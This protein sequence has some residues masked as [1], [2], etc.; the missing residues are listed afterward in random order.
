MIYRLKVSKTAARQVREAAE[1]WHGHRR[2]AA[3]ALAD[4]LERAFDLI[5][6]QP[7]IGKMA[8]PPDSIQSRRDI[9]ISTES[10]TNFTIRSTIA[11]KPLRCLP[12]AREQ[13]FL[14]R[15]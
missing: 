10:T 6:R 8:D 9:P 2:G 5:A 15:D 14:S 4:D 13:R 11:P 7:R 1:W 3:D 12:L